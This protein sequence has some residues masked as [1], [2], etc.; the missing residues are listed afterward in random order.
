[1]SC[2]ET[3]VVFLSHCFKNSVFID[4]NSHNLSSLKKLTKN[5][6]INKTYSLKQLK[7][8]VTCKNAWNRM[9]RLQQEKKRLDLNCLYQCHRN[10][11][12]THIETEQQGLSKHGYEDGGCWDAADLDSYEVSHNVCVCFDKSKYK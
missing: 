3:T 10:W 12:K 9:A 4:R 7:W 11:T 6:L 1:M 8:F 5:I 2:Y